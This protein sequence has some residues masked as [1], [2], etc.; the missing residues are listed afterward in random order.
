MVSPSSTDGGTA[1]RI[2]S[3]DESVTDVKILTL[4]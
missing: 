3:S 1:A 2:G 4:T